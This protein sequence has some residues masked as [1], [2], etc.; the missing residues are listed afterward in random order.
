MLRPGES[1]IFGAD[2][3]SAASSRDAA[4]APKNPAFSGLT[5]TGP[6]PM[7]SSEQPPETPPPARKVADLDTG[8]PP[9]LPPLVWVLHGK[10]RGDNAQS[11]NL[12][13]NLGWRVETKQLS[14]NRG[15]HVP[16]FMLGPTGRTLTADAAAR[17]APPWPDVV[18]ASG[19]RSAP[20]AAWIRR[21][22]S[23]RTRLVHIGRP[24]APLAWFDLIITTPQ[25]RLPMGDNIV[26]NTMPLNALRPDDL[27]ES[28]DLKAW[29]Q[30]LEELPRPW[31]AVLVGGRS[32]SYDLPDSAG[33][34]LGRLAERDALAG[35]GSVL[36]TTSPRTPR[37]AE[38]AIFQAIDAPSH[39]HGWR[40][41][42]EDN[43]YQAYLALADRFIVTGDSASLLAEACSTGRR[44]EV[45]PLPRRWP[46][47]LAEAASRTVGRW[48]K[49]V[50][51]AV[52]EEDRKLGT[53]TRCY[54]RCV[55]AG[56]ITPRRDL[57]KYVEHLIGRGL[58][59]PTDSAP[60]ALRYRWGEDMERACAAVKAMLA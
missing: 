19:R 46:G 4:P 14:W 52:E 28:T 36:V 1:G 33:T 40:P 17:L 58:V 16:N 39:K 48:R 44:V 43:P 34:E 42:A 27:A 7:D 50:A 38:S 10:H 5:E 35:A 53:P 8:Q 12:A 13:A 32:A 15:N 31:T 22:S 60:L 59:T 6:M 47:R 25:Y 49:R 51:T 20:V 3:P 24:W 21:R 37:S 45:F 57:S 18:I 29:R 56:L 11:D 30:R 26:H 2:A 41:D 23:G 9:P 54:E 55:H